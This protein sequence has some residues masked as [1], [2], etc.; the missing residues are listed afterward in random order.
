MIHG[1][2]ASKYQ[3]KYQVK[4]QKLKNPIKNAFYYAYYS[5]AIQIISPNII[6]YYYN[7]IVGF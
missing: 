7:K 4:Y 5:F 3:V 2:K 1:Y 6:K